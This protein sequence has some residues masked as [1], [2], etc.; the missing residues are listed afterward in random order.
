LA[1]TFHYDFVLVSKAGL[2]ALHA[3]GL[4]LVYGRCF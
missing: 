3:T 1:L 4:I 2:P